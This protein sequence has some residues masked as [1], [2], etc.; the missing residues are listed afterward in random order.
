[1]ARADFARP[2]PWRPGREQIKPE[3]P[4]NLW[5]DRRRAHTHNRRQIQIHREPFGQVKI[6]DDLRAPIRRCQHSSAPGA[7]A[8]PRDF[9]RLHKALQIHAVQGMDGQPRRLHQH[10]CYNQRNGGA[11]TKA[12]RPPAS[13]WW[14]GNR[15]GFS[16]DPPWL[17]ARSRRPDPG[18]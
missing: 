5:G 10:E 9:A 7:Q 15:G 2:Q 1:M 14:C 4:Q 13:P 12:A 3:Q 18:L 8:A 17:P 11:P 16:H 6:S